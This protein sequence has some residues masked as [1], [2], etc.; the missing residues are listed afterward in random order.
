MTTNHGTRIIGIVLVKNEDRYIEQALQNVLDF[1]DEIIVTD[2]GSTD[3]TF[4]IVSALASQHPKIRLLTIEHLSESH[5][6]I[7]RYAGTNT[8]IFAVDGDEIYDPEGLKTMRKQLLDGIFNNTWC[9]LGNVLHCTWIDI[10]NKKAKGYPVPPSRSITKLY[11]FSLIESWN[12]CPERL[13]GGIL[14]FRKD[15]E[16]RDDRCELYREY[17]WDEAWFRC[18]HTVFVSRSSLNNSNS[19]RLN[20]SELTSI[21]SAFKRRSWFKFLSRFLRYNFGTDWKKKHYGKG[22]LVEKD[23]TP[24]F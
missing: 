23:I 22:S 10:A 9:I 19:T 16:L 12:S 13:H 1:C 4:S 2:N 7:A 5:D 14:K 18:I 8:W 6:A 21:R 15:T 24:F 17:D 11:N 3:N 20:P